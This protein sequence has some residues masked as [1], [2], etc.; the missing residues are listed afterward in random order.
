MK[1]YVVLQEL[2]MMVKFVKPLQVIIQVVN[3][4]EKMVLIIQ[5]KLKFIINICALNVKKVIHKYNL[6]N[7]IK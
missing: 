4:L 5:N 1:N 7:Q 2:F 6:F 3:K